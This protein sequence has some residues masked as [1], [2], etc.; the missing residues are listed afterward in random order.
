MSVCVPVFLCVT[1]NIKQICF[2][3]KCKKKY[4]IQNLLRPIFYW[5]KQT[6]QCKETFSK[7]LL[8][9]TT[10]FLKN[11]IQN[12]LNIDTWPLLCIFFW[13]N[14][15]SSFIQTCLAKLNFTQKIILTKQNA[16]KKN[17][18]GQKNNVP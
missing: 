5:V 12:L 10:Y 1:I 13:A 17:I 11:K 8:L 9:S 7:F 18:C 15:G 2:Q 16:S 6:F 14:F 4:I 3:L